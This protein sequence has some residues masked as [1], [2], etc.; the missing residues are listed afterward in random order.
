[1]DLTLGDDLRAF[2][3][4]SPSP[5]HAVAEITRRLRDGGFTELHETDV[6]ELAP[7]DAVFVVRGGSVVAVRV[8]SEPV[9]EAVHL[10]EEFVELNRRAGA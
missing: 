4:A 8:G 7:G 9:P 6:W 10:L 5:G 1:M 3:D 2:V